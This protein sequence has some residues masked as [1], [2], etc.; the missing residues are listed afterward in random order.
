MDDGL[1]LL[2]TKLLQHAVKLVR[3]ENPH[4]IILQRQEEFRR[5]GVALT[6]GPAAKLVVDTA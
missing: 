4:Q 6:T 5:A 3:A 2:E 1:A